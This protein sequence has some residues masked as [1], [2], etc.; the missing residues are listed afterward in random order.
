MTERYYKINVDGKETGVLDIQEKQVINVFEPKIDLIP[1]S[2][3]EEAETK[4]L[5]NQYNISKNK[6]YCL[7]DK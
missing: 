2:G 5:F 6:T 4:E 1:I 7:R 3:L